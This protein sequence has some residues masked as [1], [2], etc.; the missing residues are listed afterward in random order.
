MPRVTLRYATEHFDKKQR[1]HYLSMK[2]EQGL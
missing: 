1:D 2:K